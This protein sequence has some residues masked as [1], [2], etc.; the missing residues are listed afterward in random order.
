MFQKGIHP[1][2]LQMGQITA[3]PYNRHH[4]RK[5]VDSN[6]GQQV[7]IARHVLR[8]LLRDLAQ[9]IVAG[10]A[11]QTV[12]DILETLQIDQKQGELMPAAD[13]ATHVLRHPLQ[14]QRAVCQ[15]G[16][17]VVV[18][19]VVEPFLLA[20]VIDRERNVTSEFH[21]QL[22]FVF[23]EKFTLTGVQDERTHRFILNNQRQ[24]GHRVNSA[25]G[26]FV[27]E[28][29]FRV[30]LHIVDDNRHFFRDRPRQYGTSE[31]RIF[32]R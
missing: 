32:D 28:H 19:E 20:D 21:Q 26:V 22:Q 23:L 6:A 30:T 27:A 25:F 17:H 13:R 8:Q 11:A 24:N 18:G 31:R 2:I 7:C 16:E 5:M 12:V 4:Q 1:S 15:S 29:H 3:R 9:Q 14:K 10:G